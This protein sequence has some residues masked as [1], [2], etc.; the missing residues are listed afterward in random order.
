MKSK[1]NVDKRVIELTQEYHRRAE[2]RKNVERS[3]TL[4][5]NFYNGN[6]YAEVLPTG[7][8]C[9]ASKRY[10]WEQTNVYNHVAPIIDARLAKFNGVK[11]EVSVK[12][13]G[14]EQSDRLIAEFSTKLLKSV[15]QNLN[16]KKLRNKNRRNSQIY[17]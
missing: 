15:K 13:S 3:W 7:E 6:Q 1:N 12:P 9:D 14:S 16:F 11:A 4:N 2:Q 10:F 17:N 8:I 5:V